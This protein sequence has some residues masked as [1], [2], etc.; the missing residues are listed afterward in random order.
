MGGLPMNA[1]CPWTGCWSCAQI[2]EDARTG[3]RPHLKYAND[4]F[5]QRTR[6]YHR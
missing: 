1:N 6:D 3:Y 5:A 2:I 4:G